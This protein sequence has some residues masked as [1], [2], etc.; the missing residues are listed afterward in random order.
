VRQGDVGVNQPTPYRE[1]YFQ[2]TV[3]GNAGVI[4]GETG[5]LVAQITMPFTGRLNVDAWLRASWSPGIEAAVAHNIHP[6][7]S[8]PAPTWAPEG[9]VEDSTPGLFNSL[10]DVPCWAGWS[11][12]PA[13]TPVNIYSRVYI[14][15]NNVYIN[16]IGGF[17]RASAI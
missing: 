1:W 7:W 11:S 8:S 9:M 13:G 2:I 6:S 14:W 5:W 3:N 4:N 10:F 15:F 17:I 12:I 16:Y